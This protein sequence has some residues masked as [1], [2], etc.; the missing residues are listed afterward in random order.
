MIWNAWTKVLRLIHFLYLL[1]AG[2]A[3][4]FG[5]AH[6]QDLLKSLSQTQNSKL[7]KTTVA[8][9]CHLSA[10]PTQMRRSAHG[11]FR[12]CSCCHSCCRARS[13][14]RSICCSNSRRVSSAAYLLKDPPPPH[15]GSCTDSNKLP[16][17][18]APVHRQIPSRV[19]MTKEDSRAEL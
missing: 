17:L 5:A 18:V 1:P 9:A 13:S 8:V 14:G 15:F 3:E 19:A 4:P 6:E 10:S 2:F 16:F 11:G 7:N 12:C